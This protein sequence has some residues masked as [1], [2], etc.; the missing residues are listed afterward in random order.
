MML[1]EHLL[2]DHLKKKN[3]ILVSRS[4]NLKK[5]MS[6]KLIIFFFTKKLVKITFL[7]PMLLKCPVNF[8]L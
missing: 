4:Y 8:F 1:L 5:K 2:I 3:L 7:K 6:K